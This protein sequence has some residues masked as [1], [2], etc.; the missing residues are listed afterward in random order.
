MYFEQPVLSSILWYEWLQ[1]TTFAAD[2]FKLEWIKSSNHYSGASP[3]VAS[4]E[5]MDA[6]G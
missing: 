6:S 2:A 1:M 5:S 4:S 3:R